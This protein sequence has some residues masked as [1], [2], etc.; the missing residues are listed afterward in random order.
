MGSTTE[1]VDYPEPKLQLVEEVAEAN[2]GMVFTTGRKVLLV[3]LVFPYLVFF[4][5][6]SLF[7]VEAVATL[8]FHDT[9]FVRLTRAEA[10]PILISGSVSML[11]GLYLCCYNQQMIHR[12]IYHYAIRRAIAQRDHAVVA[13]DDP[14][15]IFVK[16]TPRE[17]W[18]EVMLDDAKDVGVLRIDRATK[19]LL[20]E[21]DRYRHRVPGDLVVSCRT[22]FGGRF[23]EPFT[24]VILELP[25]PY[26]D[27]PELCY[28][29][30]QT[31]GMFGRWMGRRRAERLKRWIDE[32]I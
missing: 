13:Q 1:Q 2:A 7:L 31:R 4:L 22:E 8:V 29:Y 32:I 24:L 12:W 30:R 27:V 17:Q 10:V 16:W 25:D 23:T 14:E 20:F 6:G 21:G 26:T 15:V 28:E 5:L 9:V 3:A 18:H 11:L 19:T